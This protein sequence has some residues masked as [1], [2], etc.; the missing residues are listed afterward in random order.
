MKQ[1]ESNKKITVHAVGD[2]EPEPKRL[3]NGFDSI[4]QAAVVN[5]RYS[6]CD[7][8]HTGP[9]CYGCTHQNEIPGIEAKIVERRSSRR[10]N[11]P[12]IR[13]P[14]TLLKKKSLSPATSSK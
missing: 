11:L 8:S 12:G 7:E 5:G 3:E 1:I 4:N 14:K 2:W 6:T 10:L 13:R 9:C